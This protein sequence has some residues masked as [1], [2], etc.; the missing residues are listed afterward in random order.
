MVMLGKRPK[1]S[2]GAQLL[3]LS[4][5]NVL[6]MADCSMV[7]QAQEPQ[8]PV[9]VPVSQAQG[10]EVPKMHNSSSWEAVLKW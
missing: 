1:A 9:P 4:S 7:S 5:G 6:E 8:V 10:P 2:L 3:S